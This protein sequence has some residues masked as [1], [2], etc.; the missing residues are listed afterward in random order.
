MIEESSNKR[1]IWLEKT[2]TIKTNKT[3]PRTAMITGDNFKW[4]MFIF[5][6]NSSLDFQYTL[7]LLAVD[8]ELFAI[9]AYDIIIILSKIERYPS[10][11]NSLRVLTCKNT[12]A[13]RGSNA[14]IATIS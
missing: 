12:T 9:R 10:G 11:G 2:Q 6:A 14:N 5:H 13:T 4:R 8:R 3:I 7:I 1:R